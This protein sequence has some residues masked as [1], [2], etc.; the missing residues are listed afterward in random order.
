MGSTSLTLQ[1]NLN[2]LQT[3]GALAEYFGDGGVSVRN[4]IIFMA[5]II[6]VLIAVIIVNSLKKRVPVMNENAT[7]TSA[8]AVK[9]Y[10]SF[11]LQ[12]IA[13]KC[14]LNSEQTKMF[15]YVL[16]T[17]GVIDPERSLRSSD[18]LDKH[19]KNAYYAIE[20]NTGSEEEAQKKM[21]V[22]FSTRNVL[23]TNAPDIYITSTHQIP[24]YA[25][26]V[27]NTE[28]DNKYPVRLLSVKGDTVDVVYPGAASGGAV[29]LPKRAKLNV[30][31]SIGNGNS[32]SFN[33]RVISTVEHKGL[34]TLR[35]AH[36]GD[37]KYLAQRRYRRRE[38]SISCKISLVHTDGKRLV[39]DKRSVSGDIMD[40]SVGGCA[41][42]TKVQIP[43]GARI[44]V[45][46]V[47]DKGNTVA[48]LGQV[49]RTNR[50]K[51]TTILNVKFLKI[52]RKSMNTIN[53]FVYGYIS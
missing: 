42:S 34:I 17:D 31:V 50:S 39:V 49:L 33:T 7:L 9:R 30:L 14:G 36:S 3:T 51:Y 52:P 53:A 15:D 29:M 2:L 47:Q 16:R 37:V 11:T 10:S 20:K 40:I 22:L 1:L 28:D 25:S 23:E 27:L 4:A 12:R 13:R 44:K 35:L 24:E 41:L 21:S 5:G 48:A 46:Y 19:F 6:A 32:L 26:V 43:N 18:L 8:G 38:A 45:E